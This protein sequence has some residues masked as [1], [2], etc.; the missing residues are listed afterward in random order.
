MLERLKSDPTSTVVVG[1]YDDEVAMANHL[2]NVMTGL[3]R[4]E[5][6][7]HS[8]YIDELIYPCPYILTKEFVQEHNI[9][10]VASQTWNDKYAEVADMFITLQ[11]EEGTTTEEVVSR[12]LNEYDEYA[13]RN[14][15]RDYPYSAIGI[16]EVEAACLFLR[17]GWKK[18]HSQ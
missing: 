6:L 1:V 3:E 8:K 13:E 10:V 17:L 9:H 18:V 15:K 2:K 7:R 4:S 11:H 16:N 12:V 5:N 14:L